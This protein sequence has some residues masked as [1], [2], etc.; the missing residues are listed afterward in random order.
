MHH[1]LVALGAGYW[2]PL[3]R[4]SSSVLAEAFA[5]NDPAK[6]GVDSQKADV[7]V[8]LGNKSLNNIKDL[9]GVIPMGEL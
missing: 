6:P 3:V 1:S 8:I 7:K 2:V 4:E 9:I 5:R